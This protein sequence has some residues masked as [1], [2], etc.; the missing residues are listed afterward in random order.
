MTR[1]CGTTSLVQIDSKASEARLFA[2]F[3]R[4]FSGLRPVLSPGGPHGLA[5][6]LLEPALAPSTFLA[7]PVIQMAECAFPGNLTADRPFPYVA[8]KCP[9]DFF[10]G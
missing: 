6:G 1:R 10:I 3:N 8:Y 5:S 9:I 4:Q 2:T 7:P